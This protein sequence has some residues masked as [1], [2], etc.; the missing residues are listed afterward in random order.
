MDDLQATLF[1]ASKEK[2]WIIEP[3]MLAI[4]FH[5]PFSVLIPQICFVIGATGL[6]DYLQY[7]IP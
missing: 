1:M 5:L 2:Y 4:I 3:N 7:P 6:N